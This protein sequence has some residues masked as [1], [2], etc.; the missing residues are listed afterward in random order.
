LRKNVSGIVEGSHL[1]RNTQKANHLV[2]QGQEEPQSID[3]TDGH[4]NTLIL[5]FLLPQTSEMVDP[6]CSL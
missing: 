4:Q 5:Q 3:G 6:S 2:N 1:V